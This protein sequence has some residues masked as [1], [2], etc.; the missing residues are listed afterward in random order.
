[1][2]YQELVKITIDTL[3]ITKVIIKVIIKHHSFLDLIVIN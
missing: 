3:A 2:I 1:M